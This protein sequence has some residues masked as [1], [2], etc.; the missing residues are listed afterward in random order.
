MVTEVG[1]SV[2][3]P[4]LSL[5][6]SDS[7]IAVTFSA[8]SEPAGITTWP[9]LSFTSVAILAITVSPTLFL[10]E[11]ISAVVEAVRLV[12]AARLAAEGVEGVGAGVAGFEG[13]AAGVPGELVVGRMG[14]AG[15]LGAGAGVEVLAVGRSF[16]SAVVS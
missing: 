9:E 4:V 6:F 2:S 12:P 10:L 5:L 14:F 16:N 7:L 11:R 15:V 13:V 3:V 1:C 8:T